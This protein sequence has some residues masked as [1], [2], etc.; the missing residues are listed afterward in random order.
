MHELE[1]VSS[2]ECVVN[3]CKAHKMSEIFARQHTN[4]KER[5]SFK[6]YL[7]QAITGTNHWDNVKN[8]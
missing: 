8:G 4:D 5:H 1:F 3:V 2:C 7:K 6:M